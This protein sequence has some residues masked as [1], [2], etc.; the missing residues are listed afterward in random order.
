[1][2]LNSL[3]GPISRDRFF[4]EYWERAHLHSRGNGARDFS[5][6]FSLHDLDGVVARLPKGDDSLKLAGGRLKQNE[7]AAATG[8]L[9]VQTVYEEF[10]R[11]STIIIDGLHR[12]WHP[13]GRL[14][15]QLLAETGMKIH[16]NLYVTPRDAKGFERHWDGHDVLILQL[17]GSKNW[18]LYPSIDALPRPSAS[19][20]RHDSA[21]EPIAHVTLEAGDV[22]YLPRG[23]PH[24]A[25]TAK[26]C[27]AHITIGLTAMTWENLLQASVHGLGSRQAAMRRSLPVGWIENA[28]LVRS[29]LEECR[30]AAAALLTDQAIDDAL[31]LL[32]IETLNSAPDLPEG[33]FAQLDLIDLITPETIVARRPGIL[34]RCIPCERGITLHFRGGSLVGPEKLMWALDFVGRE[35]RFEVG[36]IPGWYSDSERVML[37]KRLVRVGVLTIVS[38]SGAAQTDAAIDEDREQSPPI[39]SVS[40]S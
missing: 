3:L 9:A 18:T 6:L 33:R 29:G 11:G 14:C 39:F 25:R 5:A 22:L 38:L 1:L 21:E 26:G 30:Q 7:A 40:S 34:L 13:V 32:A 12:I 20:Q 35:E 23:M 24:E 8:P 36:D 17:D 2:N 15:A 19:G 10:D 27:S 37:V 28:S 31:D 4:A 16:A